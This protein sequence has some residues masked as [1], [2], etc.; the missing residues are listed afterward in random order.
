MMSA[1]LKSIFRFSRG[2][3]A[4]HSGNAAWRVDGAL[5]VSA[6]RRVHTD[7]SPLI[8]APVFIDLSA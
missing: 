5:C 7:S 2:E 4:A 8:G 3:K 1:A 6:R